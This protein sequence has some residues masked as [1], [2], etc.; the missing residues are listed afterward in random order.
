[1]ARPI[2]DGDGGLRY[3]LPGNHMCPDVRIGC[4]SPIS[5]RS[6][7]PVELRLAQ[8]YI[9][10]GPKVQIHFWVRC[11]S[12]D[13]DQQVKDSCRPKCPASRS[14]GIEPGLP[15]RSCRRVRP[16]YGWRM[17]SSK[18]VSARKPRLSA[19]LASK[20][21]AQ[22]ATMRMMFGSGSRRMRAHHR[23]LPRCARR[24]SICSPRS[25]IRSAWSDCV[26]GRSSQYRWSP[27]A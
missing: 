10:W 20:R 6:P 22:P 1:M 3:R 19:R 23:A 16:R 25:P 17:I 8:R 15:M 18:L 13:V 5:R 26:G 27:H 11:C 24:A 7:A 2:S 4:S 9:G 14:I 12:Q 21:R